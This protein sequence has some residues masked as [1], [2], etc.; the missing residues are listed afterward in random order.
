MSSR[1]RMRRHLYCRLLTLALKK[2]ESPIAT[3]REAT[4]EVGGTLPAGVNKIPPSLR[5]ADL[6]VKPAAG[7]CSGGLT[8]VPAGP[9]FVAGEL[10]RKTS[11]IAD[12]CAPLAA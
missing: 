1:S 6:V 10:Q 12:R 2:P 5:D 4:E 3:Y 11:S 7:T 8:M 9:M